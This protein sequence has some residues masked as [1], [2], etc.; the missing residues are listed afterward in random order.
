MVYTTG[1]APKSDIMRWD[2]GRDIKLSK[3]DVLLLLK[4]YVYNKGQKWSGLNKI[5]L[6]AKSAA[7]GR[8]A[9]RK[10]QNPQILRQK[11]IKQGKKCFKG[12]GKC[13]NKK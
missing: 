10:N 5:I 13:L 9:V 4:A 6:Y 2:S 12:V 1:V 11:I 3:Y 8:W 7:K